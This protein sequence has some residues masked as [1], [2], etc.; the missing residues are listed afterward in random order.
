METIGQF[1]A[2]IAHDFNDLLLLLSFGSGRERRDGPAA[3][4][5]S[6]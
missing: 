3:T 4:W 1:A 2:G 6:R 5:R